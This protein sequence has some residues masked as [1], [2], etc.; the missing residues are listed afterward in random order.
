MIY[1][2]RKKKYEKQAS[3]MRHSILSNISTLNELQK[4]GKSHT[5]IIHMIIL[6]FAAVFSLIGA[7]C[8][9]P[10]FLKVKLLLPSTY[11]QYYKFLALS[12]GMF[13]NSFQSK[14]WRKFLDHLIALHLFVP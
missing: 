2:L 12:Y 6:E 5:S 10:I 8:M 7:H 1:K 4:E 11:I 14:I 13:I 3:K 9:P